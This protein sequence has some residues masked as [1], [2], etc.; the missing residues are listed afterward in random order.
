MNLVDFLAHN[1]IQY[2]PAR[3]MVIKDSDTKK[4][5]TKAP[6]KYKEIN[7]YPK[8]IDFTGGMSKGEYA[9]I[10]VLFTKLM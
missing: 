6:I 2:M 9:L 5:K 8:N 3:I 4:I 7:E 1:D 10:L